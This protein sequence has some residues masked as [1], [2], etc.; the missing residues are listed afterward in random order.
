[1]HLQKKPLSKE[2]LPMLQERQRMR[3][4]LQVLKLPQLLPIG[5]KKEKKSDHDSL[6]VNS[7]FAGNM[8]ELMIHSMMR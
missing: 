2:L 7:R 1:M 6:L 4:D 5:E 3:M 8:T